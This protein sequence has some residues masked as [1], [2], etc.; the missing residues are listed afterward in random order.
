MNSVHAPAKPKRTN[1]LNFDR[2]GLAAFFVEIGEK[3][4][5]ATQLLKWIYQEDVQDFD[6][7]TNLSKSLRAY[8]NE[9]CCIET[10]EIVV[11]QIATD[12]TCKWALQTSCGNR[13]ETFSFRRRGAVRFACLR[14]SAALWPARFA[15][16]PS[17]GLTVT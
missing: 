6:L 10:P 14:K 11:E 13:V 2:K 15:P 4:F 16:R 5:R 17:R 7:M 3:P 8:L 12:G 1:L 9:H